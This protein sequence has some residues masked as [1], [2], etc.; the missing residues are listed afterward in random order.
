MAFLSKIVARGLQSYWRLARGATLAAE[1]CLI[2]PKNRVGLVRSGVDQGWFLPRTTVRQGEPLEQALRHFFK[3]A[4]GI[5]INFGLDLFWVYDEPSPGA[6]GW[7]G[8]FVIRGWRTVTPSIA[9]D[10]TFFDLTD[11]PP[12]LD[13][14]D[15]ARICQAV[16]GRTPFEV[17]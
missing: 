11:L 9:P 5:E 10:L 12:S 2:D 7:V 8:L 4:H 1:A 13:A 17:C 16:E 14:R 15:A 6:G 3:T